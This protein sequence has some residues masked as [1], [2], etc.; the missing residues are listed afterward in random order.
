MQNF[1]AEKFLNKRL[2]FSGYI[3]AKNVAGSAGLWMRIDGKE[4]PT[5]PLEFDNMN[6]R[7]IKG[8]TGWKKYDIVL[9]I[10]PNSN[11]VNIG[12][13]LTGTGEIMISNLK[14]EVVDKSIPTTDLIN[15]FQEI[16]EPINLDFKK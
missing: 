4:N 2:R 9:D 8:N 16:D 7:P 10:P 11:L 12:I 13:L 5:K 3:K 14:F 6:N 15:R 1:S